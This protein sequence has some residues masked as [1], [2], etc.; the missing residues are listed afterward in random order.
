MLAPV[1]GEGCKANP[2]CCDSVAEWIGIRVLSEIT[3]VRILP[4]SIPVRARREAPCG[5]CFPA[6]LCWVRSITGVEARNAGA[7]T[8]PSSSDSPGVF[9]RATGTRQFD[10]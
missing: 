2:P 10:H 3:Q 7:L 1:W 6:A 9:P 4:E 5:H 8:H